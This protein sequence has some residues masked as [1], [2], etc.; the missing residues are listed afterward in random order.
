MEQGSHDE[1]LAQGGI[2]KKLVLRQLMAGDNVTKD[3]VDTSVEDEQENGDATADKLNAD[4]EQ[5]MSLSPDNLS[6]HK[7]PDTSLLDEIPPPQNAINGSP[8][9]VAFH[10]GDD[11]D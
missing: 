3:L 4:H 8:A 7:S 6:Q 9:N 1:L 5:N 2:Y 11:Y 10:I